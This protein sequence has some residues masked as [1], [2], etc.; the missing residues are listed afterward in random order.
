MNDYKKSVRITLGITYALMLVLLGLA[1]ALP[2]G[3]TWYVEKMQRP[4]DLAKVVML[5]CYPCAPFAAVC[6]FS[7]RNFLRNVL[8]DEVVTEKNAKNL[9]K[10]SICCFTAGLIMLVAGSFYMP[11]YISGGSAI[12]CA[13]IIKTFNDVLRNYL[14]KKEKK[15]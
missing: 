1:I 14:I 12:F 8:K 15:D 3:A 13:L 11:F 6:L 10:M 2:W 5:T 7:L 9:F 4:A